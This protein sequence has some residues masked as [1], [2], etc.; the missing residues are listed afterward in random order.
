MLWNGNHQNLNR[1]AITPQEA[2]WTILVLSFAHLK[3]SL[4]QGI[5]F[6]NA[7]PHAIIQRQTHWWPSHLMFLPAFPASG[8]C[9]LPEKFR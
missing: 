7:F 2:V 4:T 6:I 9:H 1:T 3:N 8:Y 5:P